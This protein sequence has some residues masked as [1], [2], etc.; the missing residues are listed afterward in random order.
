MTT[1]LKKVDLANALGVDPSLI[2]RY[3]ER[4]MPTT[5]VAAALEWKSKNVR[6][7]VKVASVENPGL[8]D[9]DQSRARRE[10]FAAMQIE[11]QVRKEMGELV[12]IAEVVRFATEAATTM[13][14]SMEQWPHNL[15]PLLVGKSEAQIHAVLVENVEHV[16]SE[17]SKTMYAMTDREKHASA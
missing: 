11:N 15:A 2:S 8:F 16:L 14:I 4:G 1:K 10:H 17:M 5:S 7:R 3:T 13:R 9:Y 6:P 12:E